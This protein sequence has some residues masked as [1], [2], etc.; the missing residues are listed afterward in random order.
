LLFGLSSTGLE[1]RSNKQPDSLAFWSTIDSVDHTP[2]TPIQPILTSGDLDPAK[3]ALGE[4]LFHESRLSANDSVSCASCHDLARGGVDRL[5][6]SVGINGGLGNIN[7][8]TVFNTGLNIAQF[9]DGR[10]ASSSPNR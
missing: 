4:M 8:P 5:V 1:F 6:S 9:W 2:D 10:V 3:I 7:S